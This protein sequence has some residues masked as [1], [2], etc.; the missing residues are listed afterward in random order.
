MQ[1][2]GDRRVEREYLNRNVKGESRRAAHSL[3]VLP[4]GRAENLGYHP[5]SNVIITAKGG[6]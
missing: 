2:Q 3:H 6:A 1:E 5:H 4:A